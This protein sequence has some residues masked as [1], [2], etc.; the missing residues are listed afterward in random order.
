METDVIVRKR[1]ETPSD[2]EL[3]AGFLMDRST[4]RVA[5]LGGLSTRGSNRR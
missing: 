4:A 1:E 3:V 2:R 5:R